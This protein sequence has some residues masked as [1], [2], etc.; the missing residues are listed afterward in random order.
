VT[1]EDHVETFISEHTPQPLH[2]PTKLILYLQP[3]FTPNYNK[4]FSLLNVWG[5]AEV[6]A[7][8]SR[9]AAG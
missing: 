9:R 4:L 8:A 7:P 3:H 2:I 6:Q 5:A 1:Q